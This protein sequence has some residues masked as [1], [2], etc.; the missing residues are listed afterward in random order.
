LT[1][2]GL[3]LAGAAWAQRDSTNK[4]VQAIVVGAGSGTV[5]YDPGAPAD[6]F[7]NGDASND[8]FGN[9]FN[10]SN[11]N[12]LMPGNLTAVTTFPQPVGTDVIMSL[13]GP[14]AGGNAVVLQTVPVLGA[15]ANTFNQV[16]VTQSVGSSFLVGQYLGSFNGPDSVGVRSASVNGQGFHGFQI[17]FQAGTATGFAPL[18]G[19]NVM[20]RASGTV[21]PVELMSFEVD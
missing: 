7:T 1:L 4:P 13:L 20:V 15:V 8:I 19:Q 17:N 5:V 11:G 18:A 3:G 12:P 14:P 21:I 2:L 9:L 6:F 10:T 16:P